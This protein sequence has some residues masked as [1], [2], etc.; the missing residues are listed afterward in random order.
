MGEAL[1]NQVI[2]ESRETQFGEAKN[3][4]LADSVGEVIVESFRQDC[5][6][7]RHH[8]CPYLCVQICLS[9]RRRL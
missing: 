7:V 1:N 3:Q 9:E 4:L 5:F 6:T 8:P 2:L